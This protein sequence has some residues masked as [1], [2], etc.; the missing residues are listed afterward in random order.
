MNLLSALAFFLGTSLTGVNEFKIQSDAVKISFVEGKDTKGTIGGFK[1]SIVFDTND[2]ANSSIS[3]TVDVNT[4]S[5]DNPKRDEHLKSADY[6]EAAKYPVMSF[7]STSISS[8]DLTKFSM[9][10]LMKIKD[11]EREETITFTFSDNVFSASTT[12]QLAYYKVGSYAKKKPEQ[13]NVKIS[14]TIPVSL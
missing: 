12:I 13:T 11:V 6:F 2:L 10:G 8:D 1:A 4:L 7:K 14:F 5:T 9:K 3:G